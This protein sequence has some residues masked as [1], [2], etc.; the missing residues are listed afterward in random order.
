MIFRIIL[1]FVVSAALVYTQSE[2]ELNNKF[3]LA[4]N[5]EQAG[6]FENAIKIYEEL[7]RID[8]VNGRYYS[9][10][11]RL[12]VQLKNY[13]ASVNLLESRISIQPS[14]I[15]AYGMLGST[16][17]LMG[18]EEKAEEIWFK[19]FTLLKPDPVFYR[20]I[21]NF[22]VE[23]R[24][25]DVAIELYKKGKEISEEKIIFSNDLAYL[26]SITMQ[27]KLAAE[28]Y[29]SIIESD[30]LQLE[31]VKSKMLAFSEKPQALEISIEVVRERSSDNIGLLYLLAHL[32]TEAKMFDQ[33]FETYVAIDR[34]QLKQGGDI[35][36][37]AQFLLK[38]KQY[39]LAEDAY[40]K[41]IEM[42][43]NSVFTPLSKLGYAK[44]LEA[45]LMED[46][47]AKLPEWKTYYPL[48]KFESENISKV[49]NAFQEVI[50][51]YGK[52]EAAY[53]AMFRV[54]IINYYL[55]MNSSDAINYFNRIMTEAPTSKV[56]VE[57]Y[58]VL[59]EINLL[60]GKIA[61]AEN[62]FSRV[63]SSRSGA[64]FFSSAKYKLARINLYKG[65]YDSSKQLLREIT[66]NLKDDNANDALELLLLL[67]TNMNDSSNI[68][69]FAEA[70]F[71]AETKKFE[72]ASELFRLIS[73]D[74]RALVLYSISSLRFAQMM[75]AVDRYTDGIAAFQVMVDDGEKNIFADKAL[76]LMGQTYQYGIGDKTKAIECYEKLLL[77]FPN[78]IYLDEAR[79]KL[80]QLKNKLS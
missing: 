43:P 61:E 62:Y 47:F 80:I 19:P 67:N 53:E 56:A 11:N 58:L 14:D 23:R 69:K 65:N 77:Q 64:E 79:E 66:G 17:Y 39:Q 70:E 13:A 40:R 1:I 55:L 36:N 52:S 74:P 6:D 44:A 9:S 60:E 30:P 50:T 49:I 41:I 2:A 59:G 45:K 5:Y 76:Y 25:F 3:M 26:Y 8:S 27:F 33:A 51:V 24:A 57:T 37:Y 10:L 21:A 48:V 15:S 34:A 68:K 12:Y 73:Q 35:F 75:L 20:V 18:N 42:Y 78:S 72:E 28:E 4:Q 32:Y 22:A 16:Y 29:C 31:N 63:I 38:E 7:N 46:Y 54:G 71:L